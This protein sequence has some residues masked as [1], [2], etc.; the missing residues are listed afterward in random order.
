MR[1]LTNLN[2]NKL[3]ATD[4]IES[5][6]SVHIAGNQQTMSELPT[7]RVFGGK[8]FDV[9]RMAFPAGKEIPEHDAPGEITVQ[10]LEGRLEFTAGNQ[11]VVMTPGS[12]LYLDATVRHALKAIEDS[13]VLVT[14]MKPGG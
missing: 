4:Q 2:R 8:T 13:A 7:G 10:C 3:M 12:L 1:R 6:K 5:G 9:Y 14:K 11:T